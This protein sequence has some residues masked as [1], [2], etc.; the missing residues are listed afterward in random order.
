MA[1]EFKDV[2][3][4]EGST[5]ELPGTIRNKQIGFENDILHRLSYK[6]AS[7]VVR[8]WTPDGGGTG[9]AA[10]D[11]TYTTATYVA[12]ANVKDAL[13]I[14]VGI[15]G[16]AGETGVQ[17]IQ[18]QTGVQGIQGIQGIQGVKGD[19]GDK[20]D[21]GDQGIQGVTGA[22]IAGTVYYSQIAYGDPDDQL[23]SSSSL[24]YEVDG[25]GAMNIPCP[26]FT[27]EGRISTA[28]NGDEVS[29]GGFNSWAGATGSNNSLTVMNFASPSV[30]IPI[31]YP[32][33]NTQYTYGRQGP[34]DSTN[35]GYFVEGYSTA[36]LG[37][38]FCGVVD[39][40][41]STEGSG[42]VGVITFSG[43][44]ISGGALTTLSANDNL[45]CFQ[46][47]GNNV[48]T[49]KADGDIY[50][51]E[52]A[53]LYITEAGPGAQKVAYGGGSTGGTTTANGTVT[54]KINGNL[55]YL[56]KAASA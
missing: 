36:A 8:Y 15:T 26:S 3:R 41:D 42:G 11:V 5:D 28:G 9:I 39:A 52:G 23:I 50:P 1:N 24:F 34:V 27:C 55:Y 48:L 53:M 29:P 21:T 7:G 30:N 22:G 45:V 18:G 47:L 6:D 13:D 32:A 46:N 17:G 19:K 14:L 38:Y 12:V 10:Q 25:G 43:A 16:Y 49:I 51:I 37:L 35:G 33:L 20:G 4:V 31:D 44:T 56:L 54:L 2:L 40:A